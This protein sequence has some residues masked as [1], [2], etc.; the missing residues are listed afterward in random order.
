V[1]NLPNILTLSR[2]LVVPVVVA[3]FF[4]DSPATRWVILGLFSLAGI[5]DFFDGYLAR[6]A[7]M[8]SPLGRF[9][10]P[11]ADKLLVASVLTMIIAFGRVDEWSYLPALVILLREIVIS[12]L[13][14]F[15]AEIQV[16]VPVTRLAKTKTTVQMLALGFLIVGDDAPVW[17]PSTRIGEVGIWIAAAI[18]LI[19]GYDYLKTGLRY[20]IAP[21]P[22]PREPQPPAAS[23][24]A[25]G[26]GK[27]PG[28]AP[29][30]A[31]R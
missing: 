27:P 23:Q 8:V 31:L 1:L 13:R 29:Q 2:I 4:F 17:I 12:G 14:E 22:K 5:T 16:L 28:V 10:D 7:N 26:V 11:I 19:T 3:L 20:M 25:H 30:S 6:R 18:T 21:A 9:L 15:L 24:Q